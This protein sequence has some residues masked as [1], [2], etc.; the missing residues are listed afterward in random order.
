LPVLAR[1]GGNATGF[2]NFDYGMSGK[3]PELPG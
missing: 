2:T 1:P 3:W